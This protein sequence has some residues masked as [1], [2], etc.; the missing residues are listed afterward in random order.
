MTS[1][2]LCPI[3]SLPPPSIGNPAPYPQGIKVKGR[4]RGEVY[5]LALVVNSLALEEPSVL[6]SF[7][8]FSM[9]GGGGGGYRSRY[10]VLVWAKT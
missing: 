2:V 6:E 1:I 10:S 5:S 3:P 9:G 8:K 4:V 7:K